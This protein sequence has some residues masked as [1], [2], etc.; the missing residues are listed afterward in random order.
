MITK[1]RLWIGVAVLLVAAGYYPAFSGGQ[2]GRQ[3]PNRDAP[4]PVVVATAKQENFPVTL[5]ALG[6]VQASNTVDVRAQITG[7]INKIAFTEGQTVKTGDILAEIDPRPLQA[8]LGQAEAQ[9]A[10]DQANLGNAQRDLARYQALEGQGYATSQQ[11][12]TQR[13]AVAQ[14]E[15]AIKG[16]EAAIAGA[17]ANLSYAYITAPINGITGIREIDVGNIVHPTDATGIVTI[18]T[19]EP[20]AVV[21]TVPSQN[22]LVVQS[23]MAKGT[24]NAEAYDQDNKVLLDTGDLTVVDNKVDQKTGT[25]RMKAEFANKDHKLWPGSFVNVRLSFGD[26]PGVT[27]PVSA[28]QHGAE[29]VFVYVVGDG[30]KAQQRAVHVADARDNQALIDDGLQAGETVV[31]DGMN[32]LVQ[33]SNTVVVKPGRRRAKLLPT[34]RPTGQRER[35]MNPR[36]EHRR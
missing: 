26:R 16:D 36:R 23:Q 24:L 9:L 1:Q 12:D 5:T 28:I 22:L 15:A 13:A 21:F 25:V 19:I 20:I 27:V 17:K 8:A 32:R 30:G 11:L 33:G 34:R 3:R 7:T 18:T 6:T 2:H 4:V 29:G 14:S 31:T 35:A 10:R